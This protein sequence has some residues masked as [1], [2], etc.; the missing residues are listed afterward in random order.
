MKLACYTA[1]AMAWNH[2]GDVWGVE[3]GLAFFDTLTL[4]SR[5]SPC[6]LVDV[7]AHHGTVALMAASQGCRVYAFE[8][9]ALA[10]AQLRRNVAASFYGPLISVHGLEPVDS[11]VPVD[12]EI[13]MVKIDVD[14]PDAFVARGASRV[15]ASS[16][17]VHVE[18][19]PRKQGG[20]DGVLRYV[21]FL[22]SRGFVLYAHWENHFGRSGPAR[23][24]ASGVRLPRNPSIVMATPRHHPLRALVRSCGAATPLTNASLAGFVT[25]AGAAEMDVWGVRASWCSSHP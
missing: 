21:Q 20:V 22:R 5:R 11:V 15:L 13:T 7:G 10:V 8:T 1:R 14:G 2:P 16:L 24:R 3:H 17:A 25:H 19:A 6:A 23:E 12:E 9:N 4:Q 18:I